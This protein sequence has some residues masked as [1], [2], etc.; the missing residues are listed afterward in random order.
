MKRAFWISLFCLLSPVVGANPVVSGDF[1]LT[2]IGLTAPNFPDDAALGVAGSLIEDFEDTALLPGLSV[3]FDGALGPEVPVST[4]PQICDAAC[5][6]FF[7]LVDGQ[8]TGEFDGDSVIVNAPGND[9]INGF[10]LPNDTRDM[11]LAF[12]T[13]QEKVGF[14]LAFAQTTLIFAVN[15]G[16]PSEA[17]FD[18]AA[19]NATTPLVFS[20]NASGAEFNGYLVFEALGSEGIQNIEFLSSRVGDGWLIDHL[21]FGTAVIPAPGALPLFMVGAAAAFTRLGRRV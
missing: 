11:T 14:S 10:P 15:R 17:W 16:L 8:Y 12:D 4:L 7:P 19:L 13:P 20:T 18:A 5:F 1:S 3:D 2:G 21:A 6:A 9:A